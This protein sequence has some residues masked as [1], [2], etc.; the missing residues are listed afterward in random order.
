MPAN[1]LLKIDPATRVNDSFI[2]DDSIDASAVSFE[3]KHPIVDFLPNAAETRFQADFYK[4]IAVDISVE[5]VFDYP[6]PYISEK[7]L[8]AFACKRM[9]IVLGPPGVLSLLRAKGFETFGDFIDESYD[10]I[11]EP[12]P[13]FKKVVTEVHKVCSKPLHEVVQYLENN[14]EK[15]DHNFNNLVQLQDIELKQIK[16]QIG[17]T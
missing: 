14:R 8:R 17:Q 16:R 11:R 5:T 4:N 9:L 15:L 10:L 12:I 13:R 3:V 7:S 2:K 6:Y 1:N